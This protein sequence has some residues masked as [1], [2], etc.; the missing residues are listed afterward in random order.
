[1]WS[2]IW[3]QLSEESKEHLEESE[4]WEEMEASKDPLALWKAILTTHMGAGTGDDVQDR[5][6]A[7]EAFY[8]V[9]Q[10]P[11]ETVAQY[12]VRFIAARNVLAALGGVVPGEADQAAQFLKYLDDARFALLKAQ[13]KNNVLTGGPKGL[14]TL[15]AEVHVATHYEVV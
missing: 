6:D 15:Q 2:A 7:R 8:N 1:M 13:I 10:N 5:L 3:G 4:D 12:L 11:L 14:N 9:K